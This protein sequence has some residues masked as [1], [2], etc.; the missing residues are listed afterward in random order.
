MS[1]VDGSGV[2]GRRRRR[3]VRA[4]AM[5]GAGTVVLA[6]AA[7]ATVGLGTG[8]S[9][10]PVADPRVFATTP[11]TRGDL[12][13]YTVLDGTV[14]FGDAV[15][16]RCES[17]GVVTWIAPTGTVVRRGEPLLRVDD[18]PVV[19]FYGSLP[20]FRALG[21][22][23]AEPEATAEPEA[24]DAESSDSD[25]SSDS[26]TATADEPAAASEPMSGNDVKQFEKNLH[27]LG[28][29]GFTVDD[30]FT[31]S[32]AQAVKRWQR[33]LGREQTGRVEQ[34]DVVYGSGA[35]RI[36]QHSVRI[37]APV[38]GDV[39]TWTGTKRVITAT[40]EQADAAWATAGAKVTVVLADGTPVAG[41]VDRVGADATVADT[42]S[43]TAKAA[44]SGD[45]G[46]TATQV[47]ITVSV[48][49][50]DAL[51]D[52]GDG[53]VEVRRVAKERRKVL[54]VPVSALLA[55]AEGG[56]GLEV[57]DGASSRIVA[58]T[59]GMFADGRVEI[60]G[61]GLDAGMNVRIPQ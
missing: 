55:L 34:G 2:G 50:Q 4:W 25:K 31:A 21:L 20:M 32:T 42:G 15:P 53:A 29:R 18:Q 48:G 49:K 12:V 36:A 8:R 61:T 13:E 40:A 24:D 30:T 57:V 58:V 23:A 51:E 52:A 56:Y 11:I 3:R 16:M 37:G 1:T 9:E 28:Y 5:A 33:D 44:G 22:V 10:E 26:D 45:G 38:P 6:V 19:L 7:V 41:T 59:A 46:G 14:G 17:T 27:S 60:T 39:L 43:D 54:S 47:P 35:L